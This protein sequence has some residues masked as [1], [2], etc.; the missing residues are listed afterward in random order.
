MEGGEST[1]S[2]SWLVIDNSTICAS[3]LKMTTSQMALLDSGKAEKHSCFNRNFSMTI[4]SYK[5]E[6]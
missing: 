1:F 2:A 6:G 5:G 3:I 4:F